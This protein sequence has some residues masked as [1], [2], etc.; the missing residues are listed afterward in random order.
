MSK[1][2]AKGN[3]TNSKKNKNKSKSKKKRKKHNNNNAYDSR[4]SMGFGG[5]YIYDRTEGGFPVLTYA[6][7]EKKTPEE[8]RKEEEFK[9]HTK[10]RNMKKSIENKNKYNNL[11]NKIGNKYK[12]ESLYRKHLSGEIDVEDFIY[13]MDLI[14][15]DKDISK[16]ELDFIREYIERQLI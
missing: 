5:A 12:I 4:Y 16:S 9:R 11:I 14:I 7:I 15:G 2:G 8:K 6:Q 13:Q 10:E 1:Y 3:L